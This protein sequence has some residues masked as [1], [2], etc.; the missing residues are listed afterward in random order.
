M[1]EQEQ[2]AEVLRCKADPVYFIRKYVYIL[3]Y[4]SQRRLKF[5]LW[6]FQVDAIGRFRANEKVICLKARQLGLTWTVLAF[7]LWKCMFHEYEHGLVIAIDEDLA[8][9]LIGRVKFMY[10]NLPEWMKVTVSKP[11][12]AMKIS[13][14]DNDSLIEAETSSENAGSG[15]TYSM[16]FLDEWAKH[17]FADKAWLSIAPAVDN[18]LL[19]EVSTAYGMGNKFQE[20]WFESVEGKNTFHT[21]FYPWWVVPGRDAEWY[22]RQKVNLKGSVRQEYPAT[23]EEA[24]LQSGSP[25]FDREILVKPEEAPLPF[26][27]L[28]EALRIEGVQ[29]WDLPDSSHTYGFG[30]DIA[31]GVM[32]RD[33]NRDFSSGVGW[34]KTNGRQVF[35]FNRRLKV[36]EM[37]SVIDTVARIYPTSLHGVENNNHGFAVIQKLIE[38]GTPNLYVEE[39]TNEFQRQRKDFKRK[40]RRVG[41]NTNLWTKPMMIDHLEEVLRLGYLEVLDP[42]LY[43]QL[44]FFQDNGGGHM[45]AP[46]GYH[47]DLVIAAAIGQEMCR[48]IK[49]WTPNDIVFTSLRGIDGNKV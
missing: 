29:M 30:W 13:W 40:E 10:K 26:A 44:Y 27:S 41:W 49:T 9:N 4:R 48:R 42:L 22:E 37:A 7:M 28:P 20:Q 15:E 34:D 11:E 3:D 2:I 14:P 16:V 23:A 45:S 6:D 35:S 19:I 46:K 39:T 25:V 8:K 1:T 33:L 18:C 43:W 5:E 38:F 36:D 21:M 31:Q 12:N 17:P 32:D 24:F 47:D